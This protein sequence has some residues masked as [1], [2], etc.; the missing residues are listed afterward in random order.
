MEFVNHFIKKGIN[1]KDSEI[2]I[3]LLGPFAPHVSEELWEMKGN[4]SSLFDQSWPS[5]DKSKLE[6]N[7]IVIAVQVNGKL[8]G[9]VEINPNDDK[10]KILT[11]ARDH[12]NVK[13]YLE[14]STIV[15]EI[16]VPN[17]IINFVIKG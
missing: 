15:K 2:F 9:N 11:C 6:K 10:E 4:K 17:K 8:R 12:E 7:K 14:N 1:L 13:L 16:Y 5:F 3:K